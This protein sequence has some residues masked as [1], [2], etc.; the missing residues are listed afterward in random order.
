MRALP[1]LAPATGDWSAANQRYLL[2]AL[3]MVRATLSGIGRSDQDTVGASRWEASA[4]MRAAMAAMPAPSAVETLCEAFGLS[5]FERDVLL[6]CAAV[7]LDSS[8]AALCA[9][10]H[11]DP[12]RS[13]PT[14]RLAITAMPDAHWDALTPAASLRFWGLIRVG[15]GPSLLDSPLR[16]D[17]SV[18]HFLAGTPQMEKRLM[19]MAM[20]VRVTGQLVPSHGALVNRVAAL[21]ADAE[22]GPAPVIQLCGDDRAA[23]QE[24]AAAACTALRR[25]MSV[26]AAHDLPLSYA[27]LD[28][29]ARL[30]E[31]EII[32]S[33]AAVL[34]DCDSTDAPEAP[35]DHAI[36]RFVEDIRGP[37]FISSAQ[38]RRLRDRPSFT[39]E[40]R[41]PTRD[42]QL[43][44]WHAAL[45]ASA[46]PLGEQVDALATQFRFDARSVNTICTVVA[47]E[48]RAMQMRADVDLPRLERVL[49]ETCRTQTR[50]GM[51]DLAQRLD[52]AAGWD[53]L[54]LPAVQKEILHEVA[55]HLRQR[56]RVYNDWG[57]ARKG[58]RGLGISALFAGESGTGKTMAAE[59]LANE[60]KLDLYRIDLS[61]MVSKYIGET[62]KNL[63]R[64]FDGAEGG[65][66]ILLFDEADALFGKRSEV[67]DSHDRYANIEVGYLL[68]RMEEY[69]G[70]A[71]LT[72][73]LKSAIDP[74][75]MRRIRFVVHFAFPDAAQRALIWA[76]MFP[77][78]TPTEGLNMQALAQL[79]V[80][81]GNIRSIALRA[82]FLAADADEPVRMG[83]LLQA[84]R[85]EYSKLEKRLTDAEISGWRV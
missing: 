70:L 73:N 11:G 33:H 40:V 62:E 54:I 82:A 76:R 79:N 36:T 68:Q 46:L 80:A 55:A 39:I 29:L 52:L 7:E 78:E 34:I 14:L 61:S 49:W 35:R 75:F 69:H 9:A 28:A 16:I 23:K 32:L 1:S 3:E 64:V 4:E 67:K 2:A 59:V 5:S 13:Y 22:R 81:G 65:G 38:R 63:R 18:L 83:H 58:T 8:F 17:E 26:I 50:S 21:W 6:L 12:E 24:I 42:E 15:S 60:L 71:V 56:T 45:A 44:L 77:A 19:E 47:H 72:T 85:S 10:V 74:A 48:Y 43:G 51:E 41:M 53:D 37:V 20:P 31:R 66:S 57:F 84:A 30:W 25:T 27:D